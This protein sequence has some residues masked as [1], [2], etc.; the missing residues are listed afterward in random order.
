VVELEDER[1]S[2]RLQAFDDRELPLRPSG[3]QRG[4][5]ERCRE[6][7][8]GLEVGGVRRSDA[9]AV[10]VEVEPRVG[11]PAQ[12]SSADAGAPHALAEARDAFDGALEGAVHRVGRRL[13][14][15][16][17]DGEHR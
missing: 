12:A 3:I 15:E 8:N 14:V 1:R 2:P 17:A 7:E 11:L 6:V 5:C 9:S 13:T 10:V 4:D 16:Q